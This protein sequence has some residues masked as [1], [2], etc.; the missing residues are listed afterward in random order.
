MFNSIK[1]KNPI[2]IHSVLFSDIKH[3]SV[4]I[5]FSE[6]KTE[7]TLP[8]VYFLSS[9]DTYKGFFKYFNPLQ[10]DNKRVKVTLSVI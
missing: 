3:Y 1:K 2:N 10:A 7:V 9:V 5:K 4:R 6:Q 8:D